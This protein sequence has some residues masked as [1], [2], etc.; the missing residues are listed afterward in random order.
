MPLNL[1]DSSYFLQFREKS[2]RQ[3]VG[4]GNALGAGRLLAG[5]LSNQAFKIT[6]CLQ[7]AAAN[8]GQAFGFILV[9]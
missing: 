4:F 2:E 9:K 7:Q 6:V 3:V 5:P 8:L 1:L